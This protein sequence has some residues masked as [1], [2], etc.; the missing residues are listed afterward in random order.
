MAP[1]I[2]Y[3]V[4]CADRNAHLFAITLR[5]ERPAAGQRVTL[6]VWI[7][8]SYLV[9]EFSKNLQQLQASQGRRK[10]ALRQLDKHS[11]EI[12]CAAD[13]PLE[14]RYQV[15]AYDNSVRTAWLDGARAF[16]NGTGLCLRVEGQADGPH[17]IEIV[18]P[19]LLPDEERWSCATA[20]KPVR[21][22]PHGFGSYLAADYDELADSP[23]EM[24]AFWSAEFDACGVPHRFVVAGAPP[25]FDGA[26]LIADTRAICETQMRFW[27]GAKVGKRGGPK[28]PHDRYVFMLNAVDDGYGGLEHRHSTAL[29]CTR[30]DLPQ[31]GLK[32]QSDGYTTLLGL[33]SHEYFHTWNVKRLRPAEF[34]RYDYGRENYTQLLWLFEGFTSYYDDLLLRRAG[35][36][37]DAGYLRLVNKTANQVLQAPGR[38]VQSVAQASFDAWVK[39]YR[40]DEQTANTTISYYTKGALVA[41]CFDLT[42]RGE[43][44]GSLDDVMRLMW[45]RSGGGPVAEADFAAA[46]ETVGGRS[47]SN[48]MARWVHSTEELPLA[49]LL[50]KQGVAVNEDPSQRAQELGLRV[51]ESGGS[52]QVKM[53]L[54]GA[55]AEQAGFSAN[56]EWIGIELPGAKGRPAQ[57]W[58]IARLDDLALYLGP[59]KKITA[60]V[61]RDRRL[62]RLPLTLP[63]G[64]TTLRL[65][66]QDPAKLAQWLS[67]R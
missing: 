35:L 67:P 46:L 25:S 57:G 54:R 45:A 20:L 37:D 24:G 9:R 48:E 15:C 6:P 19:A 8:G 44:G 1:A 14:L 66:V 21:T 11:W 32:K 28:P 16:F 18:A 63:T 52:V 17:A 62:L 38:H 50:G 4:E 23:V 13:K 26:R 53:V 65:A 2:H 42:L 59:L 58:R 40:Q 30:R 3:R 36:L 56:D 41:M 10:P 55:A 7:P 47:F 51:A 22:N 60:L 31:F 29:I 61:A 39:Y 64:V 34:E 49:E 12:D 5:I 27:H 33:I 43:G